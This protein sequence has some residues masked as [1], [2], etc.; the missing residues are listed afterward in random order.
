MEEMKAGRLNVKIL[1]DR[2]EVGRVGAADVSRAMREVIQAKGA[3]NIVFASAASQ[4]ELLTCLAED[5]S[6]DWPKVRA[7]NMDEYIGIRA[8][9]PETFGNY[10][11]RMLYDH[12]R[13]GL[14]A[15]FDPQ[16]ADPQA[17]C[18]R[19]AALLTRYPPD[20]VLFGVGETCHLAFND[21]PYADF[22]DP[23]L[24]KTVALDE[25]TRVQM[26]HDGCFDDPAEVPRQAYTITIPVV[27][28]APRLFG[29]VPGKTKADAVFSTVNEPIS[30]AYPST[31]LR[32]HPS[33]T[34]YIDLDSAAR[35]Q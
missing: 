4:N 33:A 29:M 13:P 31:I 30:T 22:S 10:L 11:K 9:H 26:V 15:L 24:V 35:L 21:P 17:E 34:M 12:V 27:M 28:N 8:D 16:A 2:P 3:L 5:E 23:L 14:V 19:Y 32:E 20:I 18:D 25:A 6:I 7:F 1:K